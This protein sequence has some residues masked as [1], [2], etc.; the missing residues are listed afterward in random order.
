MVEAHDGRT[1]AVS[2]TETGEEHSEDGW[3]RDKVV[4]DDASANAR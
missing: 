1:V 4:N 3:E 2:N